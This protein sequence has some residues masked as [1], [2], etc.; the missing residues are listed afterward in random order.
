MA[1]LY[2]IDPL[3][4]LAL[5]V[6]DRRIVNEVLAVRERLETERM[7]ALINAVATN[8]AYHTAKSI[9]G[10]LASNAIRVIW[11]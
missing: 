11:K 9:T 10:W 6:D 1:C 7:T 3:T 8:T 2:G 4:Y 5:E